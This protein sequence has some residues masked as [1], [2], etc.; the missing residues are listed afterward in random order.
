MVDDKTSSHHYSTINN[1]THTHIIIQPINNNTQYTHRGL[2]L[3]AALLDGDM[4]AALVDCRHLVAYLEAT[5]GKEVPFHPLLAL[6]Y[7]TLADLE[8]AAAAGSGEQGGVV[9]GVSG[10]GSL[11]NDDDDGNSGGSGGGLVVGSKKS[12]LL[13][14]KKSLRMLSLLQGSSSSLSVAAINRLAQLERHSE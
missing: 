13:Y 14:M 6:Q 7:F 9:G 2:S 3:S 12:A 11:M 10:A 1:N 5:L 8:D 4:S